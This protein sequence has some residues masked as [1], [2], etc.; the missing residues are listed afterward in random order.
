MFMGTHE[1]KLDA[2]GRVILPAKFRDQLADGL[3]VTRGQDRCLYI[4]T[5]AEFEN[6]YD[7]L[8]KAPITSKNARDFLR[9]LMAGASDELLDKQGRLTIPQTLRRYA[10]LERD[11]VV[12]GVGARLEVWDAQRWD[13]YLSVTEDVFSDA[14]EEIIPGLF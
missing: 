8:S 4:F 3:V 13:E 1:P 11:V 9:V 7:Q 2:K 12:T 14:V 5:K 6:I 10:Q